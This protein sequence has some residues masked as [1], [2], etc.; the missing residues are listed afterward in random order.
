ME[1]ME[2]K[3]ISI[4]IPVYNVELYLDDFVKSILEQTYHNWELIFID[5]G[6]TDNSGSICDQWTKK[7]QRI[8]CIHQKNGG[9]GVARNTGL[10][11]AKGE[12]VT[13]VDA[14]DT[15]ENDF[16]QRCMDDAMNYDADIVCCD[17]QKVIGGI[18]Q[19]RFGMV[20]AAREI[21]DIKQLFK[22]IQSE[23][24]FYRQVT[25]KLYR[26]SLIQKQKF[27]GIRN[28]EDTVFF[29]Q[30]FQ[31]CEK[32]P[33]I[34]LDPAIGY[35]YRI[36]RPSSGG[37][38]GAPPVYHVEHM[39]IGRQLYKTAELTKDSAVVQWAFGEYI[40]YVYNGLSYTIKQRDHAAYVQ[41]AGKV[42]EYTK[43]I[44]QEKP[45]KNYKL[46]LL[47][48]FNANPNLYWHMMSLPLSIRKKLK[49]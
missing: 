1:V 31:N 19:G 49:K 15:L 21:T 16:L 45:V 5:D 4:I 13:F 48:V 20:K 34:Y 36:Y 8:H 27:T 22:A 30:I 35:N 32:F 9:A 23:E 46:R 38:S 10:A 12:Y 39:E 14:D 2:N 18:P 26:T 47:S 29:L 3:L 25:S 11:K 28:G 7:E 24:Q 17:I 37:I 6:S 33:V 43:E 40:N 41:Y 42:K 44:L